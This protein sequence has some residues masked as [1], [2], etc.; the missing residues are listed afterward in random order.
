MFKK[1]A[2]IVTV[3]T[4]T[5]PDVYIVKPLVKTVKDSRPDF[6]AFIVTE[7]SRIYG[8]A[9]AKE[10]E[11]DKPSYTLVLLKE[12]D[13]FQSV[14]REVN[15]VFRTLNVLGYSSEQIQVDFTSGT[16]AMSSGA[17]LSAIYNQ[18]LSLKYITGQR[19]NGVVID[20]SEKFL[21]I[22]PAGIF[23]LHEIQLAQELI[24]RLRFATASEI[25]GNI[26][27]N[28]IDQKERHWVKNLELIT[29]AYRAW[30]IFNHGK[31]LARFQ[32]VD[33]KM[34]SLTA[35]RPGSPSLSL[36]NALKET[37]DSNSGEFLL[38]DLYNN[39]LRRGIEGKYDDAVARLY[40][41]SELFAQQILEQPPYGIKSAD[42][43]LALVPA[44]IR[45]DL[46]KNRDDQDNKVRI[47]MEMDY[48][49]LEALGHP[50]GRHFL[51]DKQLRGRVRERN[52]SILGHGSKPVSK[53][54]YGKLRS[55]LV[56]L[57]QL[58]IPDFEEKAKEVQFPWLV[59]G[60]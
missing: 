25:I 29:Q 16:K 58:E 46:E 26:N 18:C 9:I 53:G 21:T 6:T 22:N 60:H 45:A 13:D 44:S 15:H 48:K 43:D 38:V 36:L 17:V 2:L 31:A 57:F 27:L 32:K 47:G 52:E 20:G 30:D 3:G 14:F 7:E 33:W 41:A 35:F 12:S 37:G 11:L 5:R 19:K 56:N 34:V 55:S 8:E 39:S 4:G 28:L 54:L 42:V 1:R 10:L 50:V 49:L 51:E 59:D 23:A 40:R 24:F